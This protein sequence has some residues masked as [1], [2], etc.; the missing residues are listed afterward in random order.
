MFWIKISPFFFF[1]WFIKMTWGGKGN[2]V[3]KPVTGGNG[4]KHGNVVDRMKKDKYSP[5][6]MAGRKFFS[7]QNRA[8]LAVQKRFK[9]WVFALYTRSI[10]YIYNFPRL[11]FYMYFFTFFFLLLF[12]FFY[13]VLTSQTNLIIALSASVSKFQMNSQNSEKYIFYSES[14]HWNA[15][16]PIF[17]F[18]LLVFHAYLCI[19][20]VYNHDT[21]RLFIRYCVVLG[22]L[23]CCIFCNHRRY[24][25]KWLM[26]MFLLSNC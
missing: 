26:V 12:F 6:W 8:F 17:L 25:T 21:A 3:E 19:Q 11:D 13:F 24:F 1:V 22:H 15:M 2:G 16:V 9:E 20:L 23:E 4:L 7:K 5:S 10:Y 18:I 14:L